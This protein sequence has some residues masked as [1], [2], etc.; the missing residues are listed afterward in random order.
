[1]QQNA[2]VPM[3]AHALV[4]KFSTHGFSKLELVAP[5]VVEVPPILHPRRSEVVCFN[6]KIVND[7]MGMLPKI[8]E[9][10]YLFMSVSK[11][12]S[13]MASRCVIKQSPHENDRVTENGCLS[14]HKIRALDAEYANVIETGFAWNVLVWPAAEEFLALVDL[15]QETGNLAQQQ[16]LEETRLQIALKMHT[17][18]MRMMMQEEGH[19]VRRRSLRQRCPTW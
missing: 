7:S 15:L 12:H 10:E 11:S 9:E 19:S 2:L 5:M 1:M 4:D 17:S 8:E 3:H 6:E 18:A 16:C 14:I 13:S